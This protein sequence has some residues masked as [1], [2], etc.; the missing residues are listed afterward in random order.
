[1]TLTAIILIDVDPPLTDTIFDALKDLP[2]VKEISS[3][4]GIHD[5]FCLIEVANEEKLN[6]FIFKKLRP[7]D[8]VKETLTLMVSQIIR[9][10]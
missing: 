8:G 6:E 7:T 5:I 1:M 10:D 3:V 9:K 2:M 4:Y